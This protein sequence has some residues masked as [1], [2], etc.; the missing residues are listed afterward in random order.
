MGRLLLGR[1]PL[2]AALRAGAALLRGM[3]QE[4]AAPA[5]RALAGPGENCGIHISP[6][7]PLPEPADMRGTPTGGIDSRPEACTLL[8]TGRTWT[9][10]F[11]TCLHNR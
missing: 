7:R 4:S 9:P 3:E 10:L 6:G 1:L 2:T 5:E 11:R 8:L